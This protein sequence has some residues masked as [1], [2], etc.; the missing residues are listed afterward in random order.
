MHRVVAGGPGAG[1]PEVGV[2]SPDLHPLAMAF[3]RP[4]TGGQDHSSLIPPWPLTGAPLY[5][6]PR[7]V[8]E[9]QA[10]QYKRKILFIPHSY[11]KCFSLPS[12]HSSPQ[13]VVPRVGGQSEPQRQSLA[14]ETGGESRH[15][16]M[17]GLPRTQKHQGLPFQIQVSSSAYLAKF[18]PRTPPG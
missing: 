10:D 9:K 3:F 2:Q 17:T 4:Y 14:Y 11:C 18:F 12:P 7:E 5:P 16:K 8:K 6:P 13:Q 1:P 15:R